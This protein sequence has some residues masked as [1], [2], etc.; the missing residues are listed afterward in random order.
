ML[1]VHLRIND[2]VTG[3]PTPARV[4]VTSCDGTEYAPLG[5]FVEFPT[6][7]NEAVGGQV[8]IGSTRWFYIDGWCEIRLPTGVPLR[9]QITKGPEY[10]PLDETLTLGSGQLSLRFALHHQLRLPAGSWARIDSRCHFLTPHDALLEAEAEGLDVVNLLATLQRFPSL[11]GTAYPTVPNLSAFS[12]QQPA[13]ERN[14][15]QVIVN[16]FNTHPVLGKVAL[17]HSH[18]PVYPLTFGG[19]ET[20][21]WGICDWCDQCHRKGGLVVWVEAFEP[22]A[23]LVGGEALVAAILGKIDTIEVTRQP[24]VVPL[25][26]WVYR[27]WNA[28]FRVPLIGASGKD[29]NR[30]ALGTVRTYARVDDSSW[31]EAVRCGQTFVTTGPLVTLEL[32]GRQARAT[33]QSLLPPGPLELVI[34]GEVVASTAADTLETVVPEHGW[35]AAR[36]HGPDGG[37]AHTSPLGFG[38]PSPPTSAVTALVR[39][40]DQTREWAELHGRYDNLKRRD[41]LLA[42]CDEARQKLQSSLVLR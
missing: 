23:R 7:R 24:R 16:T 30:V 17:L 1:T 26:P 10:T 40:I 38:S 28:G 2:S 5:R 19:E 39:L 22:A 36:C 21:D 33:V 18:R 34:N 3:Q 8:L 4:R 31:V 20:D 35:V 12:G 9:V 13:L 11:D 6:G 37:F 15:R 41:Q 32:I 42:R 25:L 27:L 29:S 14:G